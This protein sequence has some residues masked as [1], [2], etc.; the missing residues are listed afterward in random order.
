MKPLS[1]YMLKVRDRGRKALIPYLMGGWPDL[2][3]FGSLVE[4]AAAAGADAVE[5]GLP[6][7]DPA[8]DGPVIE[9]AGQEV[10]NR[11]W[12]A[13]DILKALP[14]NLPIPVILMTYLNPI[15][16]A[17]PE[18]FLDRAA[19]AGVRG[20]IVPDMPL[21]ETSRLR[22]Q[23]TSG[24]ATALPDRPTDLQSPAAAVFGPSAR[25]IMSGRSGQ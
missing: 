10:L 9:R 4:A 24:L 14:K 7:S 1:E 13:E 2:G 8:A 22:P 5:V 12:G 16:A 17:G 3:T 20:L 23:G 11:G 19:E 18:G 6:F 21:E 25:P 15:L